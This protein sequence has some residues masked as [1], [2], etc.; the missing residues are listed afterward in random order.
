MTDPV[1]VVAFFAVL[2]VL[3]AFWL[4]WSLW[5]NH[6]TYKE[7][8]ALVN[9]WSAYG[10]RQDWG[11]AEALRKEYEAVSYR[12]HMRARMLFKNPYKLYGTGIQLHL[13]KK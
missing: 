7:R 3:L 13:E 9:L 1:V 2:F 10:D 11:A 5:N 12:D 8:M 4:L 6:R